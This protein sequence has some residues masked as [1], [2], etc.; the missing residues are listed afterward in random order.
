MKVIGF[1]NLE[2]LLKCVAVM[3][4]FLLSPDF[5]TGQFSG[6]DFTFHCTPKAIF[7]H[8]LFKENQTNNFAFM[9]GTGLHGSCCGG[10]SYCFQR[11]A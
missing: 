5:S 11:E 6:L 2:I 4:C 1:R 8:S 10:W 9:E 3:A 7:N